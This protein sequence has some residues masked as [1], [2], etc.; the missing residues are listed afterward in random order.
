MN[1][2]SEDPIAHYLFANNLAGR[3]QFSDAIWHYN[4]AIELDPDNLDAEVYVFAA[5]LLATCPYPSLR[6]GERAVSYARKA[7]EIT[8]GEPWPLSA[9][10]AAFAEADD[11]PMAIDTQKKAIELY[12]DYSFLEQTYLQKCDE[13]LRRYENFQSLDYD[14]EP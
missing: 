8:D 14:V 9:L 13:R 3:R 5:W 4:R 10:A 11:F 6:D 12:S 7:C 1:P 2:E